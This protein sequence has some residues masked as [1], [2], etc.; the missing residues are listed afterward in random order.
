MK[1]H[2]E[3]RVQAAAPRKLH[4]AKILV[5]S[6]GCAGGIAL[7]AY[8]AAAGQCA[9]LIP[10]FGA[11]CVLAT[12]T[13]TSAFAQP[14]NIVGGHLISGLIGF[15]CAVWFGSA[16]W[17]FPIAVGLATALM[18]LTRTIHPPAAADPIFFIMR[19]AVSWQLVLMPVLAGSIVLVLF[20]VV[21][22]RWV[23]REPYPQHWY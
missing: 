8:L 21:F 4:Y 12:V 3:L 2:S 16:W 5:S 9:L 23:T 6:L 19:D 17:A 18:Q 1:G 14:R 7:V 22:H 15:G 11:T 13:P 20:F 10:P